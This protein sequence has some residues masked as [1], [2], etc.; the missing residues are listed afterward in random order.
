LCINGHGKKSGK[1]NIKAKILSADCD[2]SKVAAECGIF[3]LFGRMI[4]NDARCTHE[5]KPRILIPRAAFNKKKNLFTSKLDLKFKAE[6]S[7]MVHLEH[8][9][10]RF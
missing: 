9:V 2:T 6:T 7:K 1:E 4:T 3:Q 5:M 8:R 10:I